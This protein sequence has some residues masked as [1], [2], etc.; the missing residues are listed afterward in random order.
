MTSRE[1]T[2]HGRPLP[3]DPQGS[4]QRPRG[5]IRTLREDE[6]A[7]LLELCAEHAAYEGHAWRC[8][9]RE[10]GLRRALFASP[11]RLYAWVLE[12]AGS[13]TTGGQLEGFATASL[14]YATWQGRDFLHLDC[15][16]LRPD[17]R[18][19]GWGR[20]FLATV[21]GHARSLGCQEVQWQTPTWNSSAIAFYEAQGASGLEKMRFTLRLDN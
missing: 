8:E 5:E 9:E 2:R 3:V 17:Q 4:D 21:L 20:H 10:H 16:Y 6:V 19:H 7:C 15:L 14:Q 12:V 18:R 11:P 1:M 13:H